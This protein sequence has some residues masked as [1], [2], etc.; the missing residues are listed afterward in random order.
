MQREE[1]ERQREEASG[2]RRC[3]KTQN[4][5]RRGR[6]GRRD[7]NRKRVRYCEM[8]DTIPETPTPNTSLKSGE[9]LRLIDP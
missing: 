6:T 2:G 1:T 9:L 3:K 5:Q 4:R 8:R 7:E